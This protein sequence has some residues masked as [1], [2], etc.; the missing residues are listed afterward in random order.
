MLE[1]ARQLW[2]YFRRRRRAMAL[3]TGA[4]VFKDLAAAGLPLLMRSGIDSLAHG[5]R[6][7][8]VLLYCACLVGLSALKGVFQYWMRVILIGI[9]RDIEYDLRNDL[10]G[11]LIGL[12]SDFYSRMRTGD[13]MAR[14]T[15]DLNAVRMMLGPAVMYWTETMLTFVLAVAIMLY[16]DWR[17]TLIAILPAP[18]V[19]AVVIYFGS[20]IHR[21]FERIQAMFSDI[22]SRVQENLAG[23]R[24]VRAY[25]QEE[26]ELRRFEKINREYIG[27]NLSL[28]RTSSLF[29]PLL[30][31]FIGIT[32]LIVLWAGGYRLLTGHLSLGSFVMFNMFMGILVWP[33]I[34]LGWVVNL[35]Q[36][37]TASFGRINQ[38]LM[39][40][41]TITGPARPVALADVRGE[42]EFRE[43]P[44]GI[45]RAAPS[46]ASISISAPARRWPS[47]DI[48]AAGRAR[49]RAW[50]RG[51]SI[52]PKA[53]CCS[54]AS[55]CASY[56]PQ[57]SGATSA[58]SRR[59]RF[60]SA[61]R[62]ERT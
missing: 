19:T 18:L 20:V 24:V 43:P 27:R 15:N 46:T 9:S 5:I 40:R 38:I 26:A 12:S 13:I 41:P 30:Q 48:P 14:A 55:I 34:A 54:M 29:M 62:C 37:G 16:F 39:E 6:L 31:L 10:F 59:K 36:R 32:L 22:S 35:M 2:P 50:C 51:S 25:V 21:R 44:C 8:V 56:R 49:W 45:R 61:R 58:S 3:G 52:R 57:R 1:T 7:E 33:M 53:A 28:A 17:L 4:L 42:I 47:S 11:H 23:V 60:C